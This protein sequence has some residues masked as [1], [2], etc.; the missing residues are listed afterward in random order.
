MQRMKSFCWRAIARIG[1]VCF[2]VSAVAPY[3]WAGPLVV[4]T[5]PAD[6][7]TVRGQIWVDVSFR[8]DSDLPIT[9]LGLYVDDN[10]VGERRVSAPKHQGRESFPYDFSFATATSHKICAKAVDAGGNVGQATIH[11]EVRA[12]QGGEKDLIP[13]VISIFYPA[14]GAKLTRE[15]EIKADAT[16][17]VGVKHV[18]F[19]IDGKLKT[20]KIN[21]SPPYVDRWDT[22][23]V[24]DGPHVIQ[25][26]AWDAAENEGR[27]AEVTVIVE[28][29]QMTLTQGPA[30]L[31]PS[32]VMTVKPSN[33]EA[34]PLLPAVPVTPIPPSEGEV[35]VQEFGAPA[36]EQV[37][38]VPAMPPVAVVTPAVGLVTSRA[39]ADIS[40]APTV[41]AVQGLAMASNRVATPLRAISPAPLPVAAHYTRPAL[42]VTP[43]VGSRTGLTL[44]PR[45]P[46]PE[47]IQPVQP[48]TPEVS[49]A[50]P[51]TPAPR[52]TTEPEMAVAM[53]PAAALTP[54]APAEIATERGTS[55]SRP[56]LLAA[57]FGSGRAAD[58]LRAFRT[59][60]PVLPPASA[61]VATD[62]PRSISSSQPLLAAAAVGSRLDYTPAPHTTTPSTPPAAGLPLDT[63][64]AETLRIAA[65]PEVPSTVAL[66]RQ[67]RVT[68]PASEPLMPAAIAAMQ[69]VK[70]R[71]DNELLSLRAVPEVKQGIPTAALREIFEHSDGV[72][73][74]YHMTKK[75]H[76]VNDDTDM[77][78]QIGDP[79]VTVNDQDQTVELAPYIKR[80]RTMVPLQFI[81]NT[82]DVA[83]TYNATTGEIV[84][85]SNNL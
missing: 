71:F 22:T 75:V 77:W 52:V 24:A 57:E 18:F 49:K 35:Q 83:I 5:R 61:A 17:N 43:R 20:M 64:T 36:E 27:S 46:Q 60:T 9:K 14:Q 80:G 31:T 40:T 41:R 4:I 47:S 44:L 72:L 68:T 56:L 67:V 6:G 38:V 45:S 76:A 37:A 84:I 28:N 50:A 33:E 13:P 16:D 81:A 82:L 30:Q 8:S 70:V 7:E 23:R 1:V 78:L 63:S 15:V 2:A 69:D 53:A 34:P 19:Y 25:A 74:W 29:H 79:V 12:V 11:V 42:E 10:L 62:A 26:K 3:A 32:Q 55:S 54:Q 59:T 21:T 58:Y 48:T 39:V 65:L 73:Y 85:S 66:P 51:S